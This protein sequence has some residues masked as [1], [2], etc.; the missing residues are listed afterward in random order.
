M[1]LADEKVKPLLKRCKKGDEAALGELFRLVGPE[2]QRIMYSTLGASH[3]MEDLVQTAS[4]ELF[5]SLK[6]FKGESK[7]STWMYRLVVNVGLQYIRKRKNSPILQDVEPLAERLPSPFDNPHVST[8]QRERLRLV[9]EILDELGPKKRLV[10]VLHELEGHSIEEI[11]TIV[12]ASK[13]TVKSRLFYARKDFSKKLKQK[14]VLRSAT[15]TYSDEE[16]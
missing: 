6:N 10:Y 13:L 5:R 11:A 14:M 3:E 8:E 12:Q 2:I 9:E 7:F 16:P 15:H 1:A 4:L